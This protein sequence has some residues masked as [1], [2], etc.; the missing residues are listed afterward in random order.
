MAK[1]LINLGTPNGNNGDNVRVAFGKINDN[2]DELY[3]QTDLENIKVSVRPEASEIHELGG[4]DRTWYTVWI[5][6]EGIHIGDRLLSVNPQGAITV[7]GAVIATP[8]GAAVSADWSAVSGPSAILNKPVLSPVATSNDY[9][10]L[11]HKPTIPTRTSQL[12]N[13]AGFTTFSGSWA[14]L[15]NK[16]VLFS[17]S[18]LALTNKPTLF[19][20]NYNDL[21]NRPALFTGSYLD[22]TNK[23]SIP[24]DVNQLTDVDSLLGAGGGTALPAQTGQS[25]KYLTTNGTVLSWATV[26]GGT[27]GGLS[28]TDFG[29]GFT[30]SLDSGKITTSKL[31]NKNPNPGLN[32]Q[33]TL[34]VTD[35]GVVALPDGSII[36][37]ATLKTIAGNYAGITAG[38]QGRDEDSWVW[39]DN[40]G[41]TIS[42]KT[43][44][45]NHQ[46]KFNNDGGLTFPQGTVLGT[47]DGPG[48]F[49]IDGAVDKDILIYTY[50]GDTAH[51]WTFGTDGIITLPFGST[52]NDTPAAPGN[53]YNGQAV[54]IKPG[55]VSH[56]NQ[57]LRIYPTVASPDGNHLHLTSGDLRDTDLFLGDDNQ[58]V[59]IAVDGKV[60]IGTYGTEGHFWQFGTDGN[61]TLPT[62]GTVSYTPATP[63]DWNGTAP[64]TMQAAIDRLAAAF[65]ILNSGT[66][67]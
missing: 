25:G 15:I 18:Y 24:H 57:L 48:A 44:T 64:T 21:T 20:G 12:Q 52:I 29:R 33:Y 49:I 51:G 65:K 17:G 34:E 47:A 54:E 50:N 7:D 30:D 13:D 58:F 14:D 39:V 41:A 42:T 53:Q 5:G 46:W 11:S 35:G 26:T 43:S 6:H 59:Q 27:G 22:L 63:A 40:D 28:V 37:G 23:P 67:A 10:Q 62:G 1:Q 66:G 3:Q 45:D 19:S 9:R 36:N 55:G 4:I 61:L 32:N 38:P 16:P 60:C 2:F 31:Y 56:N 8:E